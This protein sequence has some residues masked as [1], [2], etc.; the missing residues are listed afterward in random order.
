MGK[1]VDAVLDKKGVYSKY[2]SPQYRKI[3]LSCTN[4]GFHGVRW[5]AHHVLPGMCFGGL[6]SFVRAC[7]DVTDYNINETYSMAGMPTLKGFLMYFRSQSTKG[8]R[9]ESSATQLKRWHKL[10][11]TYEEDKEKIFV[12]PG[13]YPCHQPGS[14]GHV[15]Y[16]TNVSKKLKKDIWDKLNKKKAERAHVKPEGIR[17]Q[18][19]KVKTH[20]WNDLKKRGKGKG[21]GTHMGVEANFL[22][23]N[24]TA[25]S[26]W[27]KPMSM[28]TLTTA[29]TPPASFF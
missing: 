24:G 3:C 14:F 13:D 11:R 23:R 18:L 5:Q 9:G 8:K 25:K 20:F 21:G 28:A 4:R 22:N 6:T 16:N 12:H 26:G 2:T 19:M 10:I 29:P 7:L 1:H 15:I 17:A 27:W